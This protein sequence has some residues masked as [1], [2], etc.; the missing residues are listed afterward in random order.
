MEANDRG[1]ESVVYEI[2]IE[3]HC[4]LMFAEEELRMV[5]RTQ[6]SYEIVE[7]LMTKASTLTLLNFEKL[8]VIEYDASQIKIRAALNQEEKPVEFF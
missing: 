7:V 2:K 6:K 3:R 4:I 1:Q 8:L 5:N